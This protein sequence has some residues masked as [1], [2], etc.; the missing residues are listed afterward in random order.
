MAPGRRKILIELNVALD[1]EKGRT[2]DPVLGAYGDYEDV[3]KWPLSLLQHWVIF[4]LNSIFCRRE[5]P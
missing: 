1:K 2:I 5:E 3:V 4:D